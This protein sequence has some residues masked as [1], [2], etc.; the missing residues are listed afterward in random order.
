MVT[1]EL[2]AHNDMQKIAALE[3]LPR[4]KSYDIVSAMLLKHPQIVNDATKIL[5]EGYV[6]TE[7]CESAK[8]FKSYKKELNFK[9]KELPLYNTHI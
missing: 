6:P 4:Y 5:E 8:V 2:A 7:Y 1:Q 9:V 3:V